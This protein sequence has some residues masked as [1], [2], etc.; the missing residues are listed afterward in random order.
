MS[1]TAKK[2]E[3][4]EQI[5]AELLARSKTALTKRKF[6]FSQLSDDMIIQTAKLVC[7]VQAEMAVEKIQAHAAETEKTLIKDTRKDFEALASEISDLVKSEIGPKPTK[8]YSTT[9]EMASGNNIIVGITAYQEV[10]EKVK[11][12]KTAKQAIQKKLADMV[13]AHG[14]KSIE[15]MLKVKRGT[16]D[17][18]SFGVFKKKA[19]VDNLKFQLTLGYEIKKPEDD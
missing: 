1:K 6:D 9:I 5:D 3:V 11:K 2:I 19:K 10:D 18:F 15:S 12:V 7:D 17:R 16:K 4:Q 14:L 8:A 13:E